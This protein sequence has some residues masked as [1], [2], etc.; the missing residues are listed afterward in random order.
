MFNGLLFLLNWY[1]YIS[2][3]IYS[4][5]MDSFTL[6]FQPVWQFLTQFFERLPIEQVYYTLYSKESQTTGIWSKL[7]IS[8]HTCSQSGTHHLWSIYWCACSLS[9]DST[10]TSDFMFRTNNVT[11]PYITSTW[12]ELSLVLYPFRF[13]DW[14]QYD[15]QILQGYGWMKRDYLSNSR[16]KWPLKTCIRTVSLDNMT[17]TFD[18]TTFPNSSS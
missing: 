17:Y 10:W 14:F 9:A 4:S 15:H 13:V 2:H 16:P 11:A 5:G 7:W 8:D 12:T 6:R 18:S 1:H 3:I